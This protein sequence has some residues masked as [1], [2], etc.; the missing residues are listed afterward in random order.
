MQSI[1]AEHIEQ[2]FASHSD[3]DFVRSPISAPYSVIFPRSLEGRFVYSTKPAVT[4]KAINRIVA[5][6]YDFG[7]I[8][9]YGLPTIG[10]VPW[11]RQLAGEA[12]LLFIGDLDPADL[13]IFAWLRSTLQPSRIRFVGVSD[14]LVA[15]A[16][17]TLP[18]SSYIVCS[19]SEREAIP[20]LEQFFPDFRNA[21][22]EDCA[23]VLAGGV[24]LE[25]DTLANTD[26]SVA[27]KEQSGHN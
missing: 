27:L 7:L 13:M 22:G 15:S 17:T 26:W 19:P 25:L 5:T 3:G 23:S 10:D 1:V 21:I 20:E 4:S 14:S 6:K 16:G 8:G 12:P 24:K 9:R 11:I 18:Q 2:W